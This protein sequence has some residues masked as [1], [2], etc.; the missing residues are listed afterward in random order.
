MVGPGDGGGWRVYD[1]PSDFP[2]FLCPDCLGANTW[3][4][5]V[6]VVHERRTVGFTEGGRSCA[7]CWER[8]LLEP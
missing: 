3:T 6:P 2:P 4:D 7:D 8:R 1:D 5:P